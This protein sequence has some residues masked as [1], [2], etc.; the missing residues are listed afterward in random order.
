MNADLAIQ[1]PRYSALYFKNK[2][3]AGVVTATNVA[4]NKNDLEILTT[5]GFKIQ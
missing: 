2:T 1:K 5:S 3:Y 4:A